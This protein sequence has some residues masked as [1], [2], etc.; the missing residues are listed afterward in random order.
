MFRAIDPEPLFEE[1]QDLAGDPYLC[2][3]QLPDGYE[4]SMNDVAIHKARYDFDLQGLLR[5]FVDPHSH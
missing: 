5:R 4:Q 3:L 1:T 2:N